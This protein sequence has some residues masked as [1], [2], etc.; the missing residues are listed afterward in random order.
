MPIALKELNNLVGG[1]RR[2]IVELCVGGYAQY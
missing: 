1:V 2:N